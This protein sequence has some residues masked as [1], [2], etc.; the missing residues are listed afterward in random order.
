MKI[1]IAYIVLFVLICTA[2]TEAQIRGCKRPY[3]PRTPLQR[4]IVNRNPEQ[5]QQLLKDG[6]DI[7]EVDKRWSN[8]TPIITAAQF[9]SI[10]CAILLLEYGAD[11]RAKKSGDYTALHIAAQRGD[12]EFVELLLEAGADFEARTHI[13][14]KPLM[15]AAQW[16]ASLCVKQLIEAGADVHAKDDKGDTALCKAARARKLKSSLELIE[17]GADV[18]MTGEK[19]CTP[20]I[21]TIASVDQI[22][23]HRL[24][25]NYIEKSG[26]NNFRTSKSNKRR[27]GLRIINSYSQMIKMIELL[28]EQGADVNAP[29]ESGITPL[30]IAAKQ[31]D[32]ATVRFLLSLGADPA[33]KN[34]FGSCALKMSAARI[35]D[36]GVAIKDCLSRWIEESLAGDASFKQT[37]A[38]IYGNGQ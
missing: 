20:L 24:L 21:Q 3:I 19:G 10:D 32:C 12:I 38:G 4:A 14:I 28:V 31:S 2:S 9:G 25:H 36:E 22:N 23:T 6:A 16:D 1:S 13:G 18:N 34:R 37:I 35:D 8:S 30:M 26:S 11:I 5:V 27:F 15:L 7:N 29:N 33:M 17:G